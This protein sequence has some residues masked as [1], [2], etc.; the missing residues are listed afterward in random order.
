MTSDKMTGKMPGGKTPGP[1]FADMVSERGKTFRNAADAYRYLTGKTLS[2]DE[3]ADALWY[4]RLRRRMI[5]ARKQ[6]SLNQDEMARLMGTGQS[7][8]S[9]LENNLGAGTRLGT[10]KAYLAACG[11]SPEAFFTPE[12]ARAVPS[13]HDMRLVIEGHEFT[14]VE[15]AGILESLHAINNLLRGSAMS[16]V[17]R[18]D[19]ILGFLYELSRLR[20]QGGALP[21]HDI[22]VEIA[23]PAGAQGPMVGLSAKPGGAETGIASERRFRDAV[24]QPL[25]LSDF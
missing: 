24:A 7:E 9:R 15:A 14:G 23:I 8:V 11:S 16:R 3:A 10:L 22:D 21:D 2:A 25:S 18:K 13:G 19:V 20:E 1:S 6:A 5:G 4:E 17:Q 12:E